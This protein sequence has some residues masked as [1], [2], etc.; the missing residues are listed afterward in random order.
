[1]LAMREL[2]VGVPTTNRDG[3]VQYT[4]DSADLTVA[5]QAE[6]LRWLLYFR[7]LAP[8]FP[9]FPKAAVISANV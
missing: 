2:R 9:R 8:E 1:M 3:T 4:P 5:P 6:G 7:V